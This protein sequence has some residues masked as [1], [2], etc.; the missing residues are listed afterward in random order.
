MKSALIL[1]NRR[2]QKLSLFPSFRPE[3][4]L[5]ELFREMKSGTNTL[6]AFSLRSSRP[7]RKPAR[8]EVS[9]EAAFAAEPVSGGQSSGPLGSGRLAFCTWSCVAFQTAPGGDFFPS[10]A[11]PEKSLSLR[12][13]WHSTEFRGI[14]PRCS[15]TSCNQTCSPQ[16]RA[17]MLPKTQFMRWRHRAVRPCRNWR[18]PKS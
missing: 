11:Q 12:S 17:P 15:L 14:C 7:R 18:K 10:A 3:I 13:R 4:P 9:R 6:K 1:W 8:R 2:F 16:D 5:F